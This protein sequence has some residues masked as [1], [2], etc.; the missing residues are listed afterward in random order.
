MS[1]EIIHDRVKDLLDENGRIKIL[2]IDHRNSLLN[3]WS[4]EKL[5]YF[6][7]LVVSKLAKF[8]NGVLIDPTKLSSTAE[9]FALKHNILVIK[10]AEDSDYDVENMER[11]T[12][13]SDYFDAKH[14][15]RQGVDA[16]KLLLY[17][18]PNSS[19][20]QKQIELLQH[21]HSQSSA[22]NLPLLVEP[23]IYDIGDDTYHK[24]NLTLQ[25]IELIYPYTDIFKLEFPEDLYEENYEVVIENSRQYLEAIDTLT[26][27]KPWVLLSRGLNFNI[28]E[29][30][31][32]ECL[33][34]GA[35]GY[36]VG[37][38]I[39]Q[40]ATQ[41]DSNIEIENFINNTCVERI[42]RLNQLLY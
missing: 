22:A 23:I 28:Y 41:M 39:W 26:K 16:V 9:E 18:N 36:A 24:A 7:H 38:A 31:L 21:V 32:S 37:R 40:E 17:F 30:A 5:T 8:T 1:K 33:N 19:I 3:I 12:K 6:K 34:Y 2:A 14:Y 10:S 13:I 42:K 4:P 25:T 27:D 20:A 11:Y 29:K 15:A 35:A